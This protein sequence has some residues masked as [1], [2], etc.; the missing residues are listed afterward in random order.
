MLAEGLRRVSVRWRSFRL[1]A[2]FCRLYW[3]GTAERTVA[4]R[5]NCANEVQPPLD[6][7]F[8][9]ES[10]CPL[11]PKGRGHFFVV[12]EALRARLKVRW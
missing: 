7:Q 9:S 1:A 5:R 2:A 11:P 3:F 10:R 6:K 4:T 8:F 12:Y